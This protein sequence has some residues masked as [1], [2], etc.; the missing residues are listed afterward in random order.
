M[1]LVA[2]RI[3]HADTIVNDDGVMIGVIYYQAVPI[4]DSMKAPKTIFREWFEAANNAIGFLT[5]P[6][7]REEETKLTA[8][9][10]EE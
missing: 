1:Q 5:P 10:K 8:E 9:D 4:D 6:D 7:R 3:A 2:S